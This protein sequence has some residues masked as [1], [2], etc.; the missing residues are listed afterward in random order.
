MVHQT[1]INFEGINISYD[2]MQLK[3]EV[4]PIKHLRFKLWYFGM[5]MVDGNNKNIYFDNHSVVGNTIL[6]E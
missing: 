4:W 5:T 6:I 3:T 1:Q 2:F